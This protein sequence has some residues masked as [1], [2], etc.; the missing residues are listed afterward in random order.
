MGRE[1]SEE[2]REEGCLLGSSGLSSEFDGVSTE[3]TEDG[4]YE[5]TEKERIGFLLL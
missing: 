4:L 2:K 5:V 3:Q 1:S